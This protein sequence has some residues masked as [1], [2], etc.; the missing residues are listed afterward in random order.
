MSRRRRKYLK[1]SMTIFCSRV[2]G[3]VLY[4]LMNHYSTCASGLATHTRLIIGLATLF[5]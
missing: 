5:P 3:N 1:I 2:G 4:I